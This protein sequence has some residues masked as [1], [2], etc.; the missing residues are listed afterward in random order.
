MNHRT[1]SSLTLIVVALWVS[2]SAASAAPSSNGPRTSAGPGAVELPSEPDSPIKSH[3]ALV[4]VPVTVLG[5]NHEILPNLAQSD[6]RIFENAE[7]QKIQQFSRARGPI[8]VGLLLDTSWSERYRIGVEQQAASSVVQKLLRTGDEATLLGFD[9]DVNLLADFSQD[10]R[11]IDRAIH[12]SEVK[13]PVGIPETHLYDAV[14]LACDRLRDEAGRKMLVVITDGDDYGST[15][16]LEGAV[17]AAQRTN[18]TIYV[19]LIADPVFSTGYGFGSRGE[20][21]TK[22]MSSETGGRTIEVRNAASVS[23]A[24]DELSEEIRSQ[25]VLGY[26]PTNAKQ[27][28]AFRKMKVTTNIPDATV[29]SRRGYYAPKH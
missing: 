9:S 16:K 6:F 27:D 18:T 24:S 25:Y 28:G 17:E 12:Q 5:K 10:F 19:L 4:D 26:Y 2:A 20:G 21:V 3:V 15:V 13:T 23:K 11:A 1:I 29:L 7:E 14:Y 8:T 22:R